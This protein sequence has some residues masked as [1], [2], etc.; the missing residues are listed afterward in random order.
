MKFD[1]LKD[2][3]AEELRQKATELQE[4]LFKLRLR[5]STTQLENPMRIRQLRRDIARIRTAQRAL[6]DAGPGAPA[7]GAAQP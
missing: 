2:L 4:D 5:Q 6:A 3:T 1:E 7:K